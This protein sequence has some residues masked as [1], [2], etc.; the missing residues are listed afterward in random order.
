MYDLV[1][2]IA[3]MGSI[4]VIVYLMALAIPRVQDG[5]YEGKS[6]IIGRL[7][8]KLPLHKL[9]ESVKSYKDKLLRRLKVI[10]L[11]LDNFI[12]RRINNQDKDKLL[13]P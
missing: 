2:Q 11:R 3:F 1:L 10:I 6:G 12:S 8:S 13:K 4:G 9:D 5:P 7:A